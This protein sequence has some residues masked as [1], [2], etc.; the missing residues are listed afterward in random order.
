MI[1][2]IIIWDSLSPLWFCLALKPHSHLLNITNYGFGLHSENQELQQL[3][4]LVYMDVIKLYAATNN[5][6]K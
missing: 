6:L 2:I 1:I 3:N 4:H 5:K